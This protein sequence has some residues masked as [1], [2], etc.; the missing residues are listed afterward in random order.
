MFI[1]NRWGEK[2]YYS[3]NYKQHGWNGV[4]NELPSQNDVY[5]Y[6]VIVTSKDDIKYEFDGTFHLIR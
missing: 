4:F 5:I 2:L 3:D 6:K 1:F